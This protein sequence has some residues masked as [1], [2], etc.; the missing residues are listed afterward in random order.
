MCHLLIR[1]LH[2]HKIKPRCSSSVFCLNCRAFNFCMFF[3][4]LVLCENFATVD[5]SRFLAVPLRRSLRFGSSIVSVGVVGATSFN[6]RLMSNA[7]TPF[8]IN[9]NTKGK[10]M[11]KVAAATDQNCHQTVGSKVVIDC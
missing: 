6:K 3:F 8:S 9:N 11:M 5:D 2:W 4:I 7:T 1:F 10:E